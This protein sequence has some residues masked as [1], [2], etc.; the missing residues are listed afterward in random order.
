VKSKTLVPK[1][2][3]LVQMMTNKL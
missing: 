3:Q 2:R 1:C